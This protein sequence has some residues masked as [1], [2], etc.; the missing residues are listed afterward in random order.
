MYWLGFT[1]SSQKGFESSFVGR[2]HVFN[3]LKGLLMESREGNGQFSLISGEAGIGKTRLVLELQRHAGQMNFMCLKGSCI[4]HE[5]SDP[6]LPFI[7][8]LSRISSPQI[9]EESQKYIMINEAFLI[10]DS[11]KVISYAS[12]HGANIMDE[13]IVGGM[14]SAVE[15]FVRDAFGD[16]E[17]TSKRLDTLVYGPIRVYIEHGKSVFLAVVLSGAE[18]EGI[19]GDLKQM[20]KKIEEEYE[21]V[22]SDWD[23]DLAKVNNINQII[24]KLTL[25]KYRIKRGIRDIDI[26]REKDRVFEKVLQLIRKS[27]NKDPLLLV[28]EDIHWADSSSLQLL[29]YIA[30]NTKDCKVFICA[31]FR[32]EEL[33]DKGEK[34]IHPLKETIL[35]MSRDKVFNL[36]ELDRLECKDVKQLLKTRLGLDEIPQGFTNEIFT[37]TEGNPFFIEE[38]MRS[39]EEEGAIHLHGDRYDIDTMKEFN[40]PS[41]IKDLIDL[42]ISRLDKDSMDTIRHA[43]VIGREFDFDI[44]KKTT[45][46]NQERLISTLENLENKKLIMPRFEDEE[47]YRFSHSMIRDVIYGGLSGQRKRMMHEAAA[48]MLLHQNKDDTEEVVY[49]LARHFSKTREYKKTFEYSVKAGEKASREFAEDEA[50][51]FFSLAIKAIDKLDE[52][53]DTKMAK[54]MVATNLGDISYVLGK[55]NSAM[56]YYDIVENLS[57]ELGDEKSWAETY[58]NKGLIFINKNK[59]DQA[60]D[61][62]RRSLEISKSIED[63]HGISDTYYNLG[64]VYEKKGE[65]LEAMENYGNCMETAGSIN[66]E[67]EIARGYLGMGRVYAQQGEY[68]DSIVCFKKAVKIFERIADLEELAK[69]YANLG[70]SYV[71]IDYE[72]AIKYHKRSIEIADKTGYI[73]IKGYGYLNTAYTFIK[74]NDL[75]KATEY[76]NRALKIFEKLHERMSV[77]MT[78]INY[79]TIYRLQKD[80]KRSADYFK[81]ATEI[82]RE[83]NTPY[84]LG[85]VYYESGLLNNDMGEHEDANKNFEKALKL[86]QEL[87]N[88]EMVNKVEKE[89]S[90]YN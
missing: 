27:S 52:T 75:N 85:I 59:W 2:D 16:G 28:L 58:R 50:F 13:D 49:D 68:Y 21:D 14:L 41:S 46:L 63:L 20:V 70:M 79:G 11:G 54:L 33:D 81:K 23:G 8:A 64:T 31:T 84:Y 32:P 65:L 44:L 1:M 38:V 17:S 24:Q 37:Q 43:S 66:D 30:R 18:P 77:S 71:F 53:V 25:V 48:F 22:I 51:D 87:Q 5:I 39:L 35:R 34:S 56:E 10:D 72:E 7:T 80:W 4:Y 36:V 61:N 19:R 12:R 88:N 15:A 9:V 89:L 62:L 47:E 57:K 78:Y 3:E 76:L 67:Q 60:T 74:K 82:C 83:I 90:T 45:G 55:W 42:R 73:R 40:I 26:K 86:F 6:Y 69:A 29:S